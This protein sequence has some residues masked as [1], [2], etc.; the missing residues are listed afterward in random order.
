MVHRR[1][2]SSLRWDVL[3]IFEEL[4]AGLQKVALRGVSRFFTER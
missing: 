4:K 1:I 2:Q 3:R